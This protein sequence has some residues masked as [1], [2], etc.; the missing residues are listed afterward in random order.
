MGQKAA[1][2]AVMRT[3]GRRRRRLHLAWSN[4]VILLWKTGILKNSKIELQQDYNMNTVV[5]I[6]I[7]ISHSVDKSRT[8]S[9]RVSKCGAV[10][11]NRVCGNQITLEVPCASSFANS[12]V[13][14]S[15]VFLTLKIGSLACE[16]NPRS[17]RT[18]IQTL[19]KCRQVFRRLNHSH[20]YER[21]LTLAES[22][23]MCAI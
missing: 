7:T 6:A 11:R 5:I 18:A 14:S 13:C 1:S 2:H 12:S 21:H 23:V 16:W 15:G 17:K 20:F 3:V 8:T 10:Y 22:A 9:N 19:R 4:Y